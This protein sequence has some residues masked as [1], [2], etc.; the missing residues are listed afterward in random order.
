MLD[1]R[2]RAFERLSAAP[3]PDVKDEKWRYSAVGE[4]DLDRFRPV[5]SLGRDYSSPGGLLAHAREALGGIGPYAAL[6]VTLGGALVSMDVAKAAEGLLEVHPIAA[7]EDPPASLGRVLERVLDAPDPFVDMNDAFVLDGVHVLVAKGASLEDPVVVVN[8]AVPPP[9][10]DDLSDRDGDVAGETMGWA[11]FPRMLVEVAEGARA[12]ILE[13]T[14]DSHDGASSAGA[15]PAAS[16]G[17]TVQAAAQ[18]AAS[19]HSATGDAATG[20]SATGHSASGDAATGH[21]LVSQV[22]ELLVAEGASLS[23][24]SVQDLAHSHW[25]FGTLAADVAA[26]GHLRSF[27]VVLGGRYARLSTLCALFGEGASSTLDAAYFG[28]GHQVHDFLTV[29]DHLAPRT[30]SELLF[31][32]AVGDNARSAY[33]G[34]IR[35]RKGAHGADAFQANHNLVLSEGAHADSIPNLQIEEN[36]VRCSHASTVG[37]VDEEQRFYLESRGV[38]PLEADRLVVTGF[39]REAARRSSIAAAGRML[40]EAVADRMPRGAK[41]D[42]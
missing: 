5:A 11:A 15:E 33:N 21:G 25:F 2:V 23:Y 14:L 12:S 16:P 28:T 31:E 24:A 4:L 29:Q 6:V 13:L 38:S 35:V 39:F 20:H 34:L 17:A 36:D 18:Y 10:A 22:G 1:R 3:L 37:P 8:L 19:G 41:G 32:G 27:S 9:A 30:R 42:G 40:E 26:G 7:S